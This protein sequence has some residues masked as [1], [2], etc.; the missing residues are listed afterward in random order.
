MCRHRT[1]PVAGGDDLMR[2]DSVKVILFMLVILLVLSGAAS[3]SEQSAG[4]ATAVRAELSKLPLSF[5]PNQGQADPAVQF[6]AK[7]EGHTIFF[8]NND[9]VL[10]ADNDGTPVVFSTTIA[11][12]DPA[13]TVVGVE[14]LPGTASFFIGYDQ[15]DWHSGI[16]TYG[17]VEYQDVLPG[18]DLTYRGTNGVLKR[19]F[20]VAPGADASGITLVYNAVDG[21]VYGPDGTLQVK[22]PSGLLT[23]TAPVCYQVINGN[24]INIPA[25]YNILGDGR[26][27]FDIG[28]Y[29]THYP[30][31]IDP[32]LLYSN[33]LGGAHDDAAN[34]IA[35]DS[36]GNAYLTG[37]TESTNFPITG[38]SFNA[39]HNGCNTCSDVFV[40]KLSADGKK[41]L[42]STYL[43]GNNQDVGNGIVV[44]AAGKAYVTGYT[45]SLNFPTPNGTI[46]NQSADSPYICPFP[47]C[48]G[49]A[50]AFV[51]EISA[52]GSTL[53]NSTC[54]GGNGT[55]V[56]TSIYLDQSPGY[57]G[58]VYVT[59]YTNSDGFPI[60]PTAYQP[61][62]N[63]QS[64]PSTACDAFTIWYQVGGASNYPAYSSFFGGSGNDEGLGITQSLTNTGNST[65]Y[66][67]GWTQSTNFTTTPGAFY[68]INS[69]GKDGFV[70]KFND[71]SLPLTKPTLDYST[72]LGG[73]DNDECRG[74][75]IA[76]ISGS[77]YAFVTGVTYSA[78]FPTE[79]PDAKFGTPSYG[80]SQFGDA[81]ITKL[82]PDGRDLNWSRYVG[83]TNNDG[84]NSIALD[85][86]NG[87][88][89]TGYTSS[90][91]FPIENPIPGFATKHPF[92]DAFIMMVNPDQTINFS[93][94]LGGNLDET[95]TGIT[96]SDPQS[97]AISGYT[98]S[99]DFP[100]NSLIFPA[101]NSFSYHNIYF[102][103][104]YP[105][106]VNGFVAK[107]NNLPKPAKPVA[108]FTY[109]IL[110]VTCGL[111][112]CVQ[113][114]DTS[115][116]APAT[117]LWNFGDGGT[118]HAV[119]PS[120]C[121]AGGSYNVTLTVSNAIDTNSTTKQIVIPIQAGPKFTRANSKTAINEIHVAQNG[122]QKVSLYL[123][124]TPCGLAG[125][126]MTVS[127]R[128]TAPPIPWV[129]N[130]AIANITNVSRP[131][132]IP[133]EVDYFRPT[134]HVVDGYNV[135]F[136]G[137]DIL[138]AIKPLPDPSAFNVRLANFTIQ[139]NQKGNSTLHINST[140][141]MTSD[142]CGAITLCPTDANLTVY[143]ET[144]NKIPGSIVP[145]PTVAPSTPTD[146]N[147]DG[148]YE[149]INGDMI[150]NYFDV[151]DFA[152]WLFWIADDT[153][154]YQPFFDF[155]GD[156][157][158]NFLD[159]LTLYYNLP[160]LT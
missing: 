40:T 107:I 1:T 16:P 78:N 85:A 68:R 49:Q 39:T 87:I 112:T 4:G 33:Y 94:Y 114:T 159:V 32:A 117:Y 3:A 77:L 81:F 151:I 23:E 65:F 148:L 42:Y 128:N 109:T 88:Y 7:A 55:D 153:N 20:I 155:N 26:V 149:D 54:F 91:D 106:W 64:G 144:L 130:T 84:A 143:V 127:F 102:G 76:N 129:S 96:V 66:V 105:G 60:S 52:D 6:L 90:Y 145:P 83:G 89:I 115:T 28:A 99:Y 34:G 53:L 137:V 132:W 12:I 59:G 73:Y 2:F 156:G 48:L 80:I 50:D 67:T 79:P 61:L 119:S 27:G 45:A 110:P 18:V 98:T 126:N 158:V 82:Q 138:N 147:G 92:Q 44:D 10:V 108:N 104:K 157:S 154:E 9:V 56:G 118:S 69:G 100:V 71:D 63:Q 35:V 17:G 25:R 46:K 139:G 41:L 97:I 74:I 43:G 125:Y 29:D 135:T 11:G 116:G 13:T 121:Y 146:P 141:M 36:S 134:S 131:E 58:Y 38:S 142:T 160:H 122:S 70:S 72:Y 24:T 111:P 93:T 75:D 51:S 120:Y 152:D 22:T 86:Y 103:N 133:E 8:T 30:L 136:Q 15:A 150:Y 140:Q 62:L 37:Y 47:G 21:I 95:G 113:F 101:V 19:E 124:A 14:P 123:N 57:E 31:V 5:I